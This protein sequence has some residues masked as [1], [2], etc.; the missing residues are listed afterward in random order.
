MLMNIFGLPNLGNTCYLNSA[1]QFL[2]LNPQFQHIEN[3]HL[4]NQNIKNIKKILSNI[5]PRF[6]LFHQQDAGEALLL[7][8]EH[9]NKLFNSNLYQFKETTRVKC[10]LIKCLHHEYSY[11]KS[12]ALLLN[13]PQNITPNT[14]LTLDD[15]YRTIKD[16]TKLQGE[17][18]WLCPKCKIKSVASK[19]Y[20]FDEWNQYLIVGLKRFEYR[21][22]RYVKNNTK[23][24]I[25]F[26]WRH[27]YKLIGAIIHS[28]NINGGHY[29]AVGFKNNKWYLFNDNNVTE[30][31]HL[32][33]LK[34]FL[35]NGYYYLYKI[36][37]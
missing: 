36:D 3:I 34:Q 6:K 20:Y 16:A 24:D 13:L 18:A 21:G 17:E 9:Y 32:H 11:R 4:N 15:L 8:L 30:I 25:P 22:T 27:N 26:V 5:S 19:R 1:V 2:L 28:G 29:V 12:D 33:V 14:K 37:N 23:I 31:T 35:S 10:K 7:L